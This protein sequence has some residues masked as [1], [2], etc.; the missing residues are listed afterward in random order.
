MHVCNCCLSTLTTKMLMWNVI[1]YICAVQN[2]Y[3]T[4]LTM[5][6]KQSIMLLAIVN[7]EACYSVWYHSVVLHY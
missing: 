3:K 5:Y 6:Y 4:W 1:V 7:F 2:K